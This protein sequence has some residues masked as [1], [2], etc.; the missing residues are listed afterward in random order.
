VG[1]DAP[2]VLFGVNDLVV[3]RTGDVTLVTHRSHAPELK[4][5]LAELPPKLRDL[6][7]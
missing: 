1:D 4:R 3:V 6:G 2:V 7:N 5:L